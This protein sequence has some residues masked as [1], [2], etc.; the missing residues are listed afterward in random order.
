MRRNL[1]PLPPSRCGKG[2]SES[3]PSPPLRVGEGLGERFPRARHI[4]AGQ[5]V[6]ATKVQ[7]AKELRRQMTEAE[8]ILWQHLRRNQLRGFH[9]RR[10]QV[11]D[12]FIADFYC[13]AAG[14]VIEVDGGVHGE[15]AGYDEER[16][17]VL[18]QR[19]LRV[20]R[21]GNDEVRRDLDGVLG[22]IAQACRET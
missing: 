9:F 22:R 20:L 18:A 11:I 21:I 7:R 19:G 6:D 2:E 13:H 10:Q 14:L 8:L 16:D 1:T 4:V 17:R 3:P 15:Q 12:G 5:K